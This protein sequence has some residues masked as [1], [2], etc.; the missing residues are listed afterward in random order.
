MLYLISHVDAEM[1]ILFF[2]QKLIKINGRIGNSITLQARRSLLDRIGI[3][4]PL[5]RDL[6]RTRSFS[7]P[8]VPVTLEEGKEKGRDRVLPAAGNLSEPSKPSTSRGPWLAD[9]SFVLSRLEIQRHG[10]ESVHP[11]HNLSFFWES[12]VHGDPPDRRP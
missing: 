2:S 5:L 7:R 9:R 10:L 8:R 1:A 6:S 4:K 11:V 12:L 3:P